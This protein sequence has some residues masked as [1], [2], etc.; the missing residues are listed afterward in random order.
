MKSTRILRRP[1]QAEGQETVLA[2]APRKPNWN[3][4]R[5]VER[6]MQVLRARTDRAV[7]QLVCQPMQQN[8]SRP[9]VEAAASADDEKSHRNQ[10]DEFRCL[11][12]PSP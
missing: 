10:H 4:K 8:K 11:C 3:L 7:V 2:V 9:A 6:K 12:K 1:W 5:D